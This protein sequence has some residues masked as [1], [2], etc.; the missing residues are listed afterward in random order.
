MSEGTIREHLQRGD[1]DGAA[2]RALR[3]YGAEIFG[4]LLA[5][6]KGDAPAADE[7]FARFS[8]QLWRGLSG[9]AW[10]SSLRTWAYGVARNAFRAEKRAANRRNRRFAL[11]PHEAGSPSG[12]SPRNPLEAAIAEV[13]SKTRS[14]VRAARSSKIA[15]LRASLAPEDQML[16]IL[17]VDRDLQWIELA[18]IFLG[19]EE[20]PTEHAL[21]RESARLRKRFQL[22]K[23]RLLD[24]GKERGLVPPPEE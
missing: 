16:L 21:S 18:R 8:E 19:G 23:K 9:F 12:S 14:S 24:L 6:Y 20:E 3:L 13:R 7:G 1:V 4:F 11:F 2:T 15:E 5:L 10:G 22:I 17:R